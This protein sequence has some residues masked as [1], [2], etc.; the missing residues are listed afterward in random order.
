MNGPGRMAWGVMIKRV[1]ACPGPARTRSVLTF[2]T[3]VGGG[4]S[5]HMSAACPHPQP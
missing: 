5:C 1:H 3:D 2:R 4:C